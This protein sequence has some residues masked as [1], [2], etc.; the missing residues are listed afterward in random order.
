M[1]PSNTLPVALQDDR[2]CGIRL[3]H[4]ADDGDGGGCVSWGANSSANSGPFAICRALLTFRLRPLVRAVINTAEYVTGLDLD[5]D[6]DVG[7]AGKQKWAPRV[8]A[9]KAR[10]R[11]TRGKAERDLF[12]AEERSRP[13][14]SRRTAIAVGCV[15]VLLLV[16]LGVGAWILFGRRRPR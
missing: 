5:G 6:G 16:G 10:F 7:K 4:G 3:A 2:L 15:G 12:S 11:R 8:P 9:R 1:L 13:R 14:C